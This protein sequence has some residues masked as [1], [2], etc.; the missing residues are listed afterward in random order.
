MRFYVPTEIYVEKDCIKNHA[1]DLLAIGKRALI[2]T[3]HTSAKLNGSLNDVMEILA[4]N[5]V[6]YQVFDQVE[7]NPST[8]TV[9]NAAQTAREFNAD[10][11][12]GIGG[13]F[14]DT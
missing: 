11:I 8:D 9:A 14:F 6:P 13:W 2:M 4:A 1:K 3:G 7:E 5:N 12:I 10:F